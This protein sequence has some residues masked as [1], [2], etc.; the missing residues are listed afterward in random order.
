MDTIASWDREPQ[1]PE[2]IMRN[3]EDWLLWM[4]WFCAEHD[5]PKAA[6]QCLRRA[7]EIAPGP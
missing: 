2:D 4:A 6:A 5:E 1:S 3:V 7:A